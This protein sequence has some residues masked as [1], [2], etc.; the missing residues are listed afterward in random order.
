MSEDNVIRPVF[1]GGQAG[2]GANVPVIS[3]A[4]APPDETSDLEQDVVYCLSNLE[5]VW[6]AHLR[7]DDMTNFLFDKVGYQKTDESLVLRQPIVRKYTFERFCERL[8]NTTPGEWRAQPA[9]FG[10][11]FLEFHDRQNAIMDFLEGHFDRV[12]KLSDED[13]QILFAI[14]V[15]AS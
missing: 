2:K 12:T 4:V 6:R 10:A 7:G 9:F 5:L 11:L 14:A 8:L 13:T 1:G 15:R 3:E